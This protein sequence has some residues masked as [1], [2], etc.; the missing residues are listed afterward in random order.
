M[1]SIEVERNRSGS[2]EFLLIAGRKQIIPQHQAGDYDQ[3]SQ[4]TMAHE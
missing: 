3:D 4:Q 2:A 1:T